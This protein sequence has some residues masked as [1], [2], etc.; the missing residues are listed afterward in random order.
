MTSNHSIQRMRASR[1]TRVRFVPRRRLAP[2]ADADR[3]VMRY[4]FSRAA[5]STVGAQKQILINNTGVG[6]NGHG[7][8]EGRSG[9]DQ[10]ALAHQP[11]QPL[12]APAG[13]GLDRQP[14]AGRGRAVPRHQRRL[15]RYARHIG[16]SVARRLANG[17]EPPGREPPAKR[18]IQA[19]GLTLRG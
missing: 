10:R 12:A 16:P 18:G 1:L 2:T 4:E 8:M 14:L 7:R 17:V 15:R 19:L 5:L 11:I 3:S 9:K 6:G 13:D